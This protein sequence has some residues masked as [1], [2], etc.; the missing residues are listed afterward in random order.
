MYCRSCLVVPFLFAM[1]IAVDQPGEKPIAD[2]TAG[3]PL[4]EKG[5]WVELEIKVAGRKTFVTALAADRTNGDVYILPH[6]SAPHTKGSQGLW[7]SADKG[8]NFVRVDGG[9]VSGGGWNSFCID[10]DPA[11]N[12][13]AV[14]PMYGTG[15]LTLDGGKTWRPIGEH[16]DYGSVDWSDPQAQTIMAT[17]HER[18]PGMRV[19]MDG[20][21]EWSPLE[22]SYRDGLGVLDGQTLIYASYNSLQRSTDGG[23]TWVK[24]YDRPAR[25]R[26]VR[27]FKGTAYFLADAGLLVSKDK[28]ATW[29]VQ[30]TPLPDA[31]AWIGPY[32]GKSEN[33]ILVVGPTGIYESIDAGTNWKLVTALPEA[34]A[35]KFGDRSR[36]WSNGPNLGF[37]PDANILYICLANFPAYRYERR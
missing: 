21:K 27:V 25:S 26:A 29:N 14:F 4:G 6:Y 19:T 1:G 35:S 28:G 24:V 10:I 18:K 16:F 15:A 20:G 32:F 7:K 31:N 23:K 13:L 8:A 11:G 30:G 17:H 12:R 22:Y 34:Y 36:S 3:A 37:D 9:K 5:K 2:K 33:H